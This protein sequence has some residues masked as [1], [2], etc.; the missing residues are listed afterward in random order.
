MTNRLRQ[1]HRREVRRQRGIRAE[2]LPIEVSDR[3]RVAP[4]VP[5]L[6]ARHRQRGRLRAADIRAGSQSHPIFAPLE[7]EGRRAGSADRESDRGVR[8]NR[9]ILRLAGY[10]RIPH[11][12]QRIR[13]ES[14]AKQVGHQH[15]VG[16][17]PGRQHIGQ[18]QRGIDRPRQVGPV[19]TP[20]IDEGRGAV[21]DDLEGH[22]RAGDG[23]LAARLTRN[24]WR[25]ADDGHVSHR[26]IGGIRV[27]SESANR[28]NI[29]DESPKGGRHHHVEVGGT[30]DREGADGGHDSCAEVGATRR[31][32]NKSDSGRQGVGDRHAHRRL[33][34]EV[35]GHQRVS[36]V[37]AHLDRIGRC[38][39]GQPQIGARC[40]TGIE[41]AADVELEAVKRAGLAEGSVGDAQLP[42]SVYSLP[43]EG[44]E[45]ALRP[46]RAGERRRPVGDGCSGRIVED[47]EGAGAIIDSAAVILAGAAALVDERDERAVRVDQG[48]YQVGIPA[49]VQAN[50]RIDIRNDTA[51]RDRDRNFNGGVI[52]DRNRDASAAVVVG[53]GRG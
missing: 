11:G 24:A 50:T 12:Q 40:T 15:G 26:V 32:G 19:E 5:H 47:G 20:L 6:D 13:A 34:A 1:N 53:N 7:A 31:G 48:D 2:H 16:T 29:G 27:G 30:A 46:V 52:S 41:L 25:G 22:V 8:R 9:L 39:H 44:G 35:G 18:R 51:I 28:D 10:P 36:Q 38:R 23:G 42:R 21:S 37:L 17:G 3:H 14:G 45:R 4:K 33:R 49:V 43:I